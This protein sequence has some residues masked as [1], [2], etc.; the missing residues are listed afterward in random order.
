MAREIDRKQPVAGVQP[1]AGEGDV[2]H[3]KPPLALAISARRANS[4]AN[5]MTHQQPQR[6]QAEREHETH[7]QD[8]LG[9]RQIAE[10]VDGGDLPRAQT[11]HR[12]R[13]RAHDGEGHHAARPA[14]ARPI[15]T[16]KARK[17][18]PAIGDE[19]RREAGS[20]A[21]TSSSSRA[22]GVRRRVANTASERMRSIGPREPGARRITTPKTIPAAISGEQADEQHRHAGLREDDA[23]RPEAS[24]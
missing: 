22:S 20:A 9:R 2:V 15:S 23:E 24:A 17:A 11:R 10:Q 3:V 13:K 19:A 7:R 6:D 1:L 5:T 21:A 14:A 16:P 8:G 4:R 18:A 12:D